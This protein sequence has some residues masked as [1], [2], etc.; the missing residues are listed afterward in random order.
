MDDS[1]AQGIAVKDALRG[2][3]P[4]HPA[5]LSLPR[6]TS[7]ELHSPV[8][9]PESSP[10][11][12]SRSPPHNKRL[13]KLVST[14]GAILPHEKP[15]DRW[16]KPTPAW[17]VWYSAEVRPPTPRTQE[18]IDE[19][20]KLRW[21]VAEADANFAEM[22]K[23]WQEKREELNRHMQQ[24]KNEREAEKKVLLGTSYP[25]EEWSQRHRHVLICFAEWK[26]YRY[27]NYI[28]NLIGK[29]AQCSL[30]P[31]RDMILKITWMA[32]K[33]YHHE[34]EILQAYDIVSFHPANRWISE[35]LGTLFR[36]WRIECMSAV[37]ERQKIYNTGNMMYHARGWFQIMKTWMHRKRCAH[38]VSESMGRAWNER[39]LK[40]FFEI[41]RRW[42]ANGFLDVCD[43]KAF[44]L[45]STTHRCFAMWAVWTW[46]AARTPA[47]SEELIALQKEIPKVRHQWEIKVQR[48]EDKFEA[49]RRD[50]Q[51]YAD[52][53]LPLPCTELDR[54]DDLATQ[55]TD[56]K[57]RKRA[58][59]VRT[60]LQEAAHPRTPPKGV[61]HRGREPLS[62]K[63]FQV[64]VDRTLVG[65]P[66]LGQPV[67][68][69]EQNQR[70]SVTSLRHLLTDMAVLEET[71]IAEY[72]MVCEAKL[73]RKGNSSL[74][75]EDFEELGI[76]VSPRSGGAVSYRYPRLESAPSRFHGVGRATV[77]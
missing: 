50:G 72:A 73:Y 75:S 19:N 26:S 43:L 3:V 66:V 71:Q 67:N 25:H 53:D 15:H 38:S 51:L 59:E 41:W 35:L 18:L 8:S 36:I 46:S 42:D 4:R 16:P 23:D 6:D 65:E 70:K 39:L 60:R 56:A 30:L 49:I 45:H 14:G 58:E 20:T 12:R 17:D 57:M 61:P 47:W 48:L 76:P 54:L 55:R 32:W 63:A 37:Y 5:R 74:G 21:D 31:Q 68:M 24:A 28:T 77:A 34:R 64:G 11:P 27:V 69:P 52:F 7:A 29:V 22:E 2:D 9:S 1:P 13:S 44:S 62:P 33:S 40:R 10:S